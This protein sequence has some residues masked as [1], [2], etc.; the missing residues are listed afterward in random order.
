MTNPEGVECV[1]RR[2]KGSTPSGSGTLLAGVPIR[3]FHPRLMIL[4]PFGELISNNLKAPS[5]EMCNFDILFVHVIATLAR[6]LGPSGIRSVA[7]ESVL[8]K[9]QLLILN[10]SRQRHPHLLE[11]F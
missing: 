4:F 1:C 11:H 8:V 6:L 2:Y 9:Q 5:Y 7:A 10:R 3:G